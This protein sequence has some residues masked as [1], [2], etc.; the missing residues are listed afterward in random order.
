[1][2][3]TEK[4]CKHLS[5]GTLRWYFYYFSSWLAY[6]IDTKCSLQSKEGTALVHMS[7]LNEVIIS[8]FPSL[9]IETIGSIMSLSAI[10]L[11]ST[12]SFFLDQFPWM[13]FQTLKLQNNSFQTWLKGHNSMRSRGAWECN[14]QPSH[15]H[16]TCN[17]TLGMS[18][19]ECPLDTYTSIMGSH[20]LVPVNSLTAAFWP[21]RISEMYSKATPH[22]VHHNNIVYRWWWGHK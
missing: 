1:M 4:L 15:L 2:T 17:A 18:V 7:F 3:H 16:L 9:S 21:F 10:T 22:R 8:I 6:W 5:S 13:D 11:E 14:S 20:W 12:T 19:S